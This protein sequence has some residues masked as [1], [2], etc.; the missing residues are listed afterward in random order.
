MILTEI[1]SAGELNPNNIDAKMIYDELIALGHPNV[2]MMC[3]ADI[4]RSLRGQSELEGVVAFLGA[5]NIGE[6]ADDCAKQ[7]KSISAA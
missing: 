4:V 6:V 2:Q 5:G 1:Y 3:K 7:F